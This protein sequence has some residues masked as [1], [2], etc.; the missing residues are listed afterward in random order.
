MA[1]SVRFDRYPNMTKDFVSTNVCYFPDE[2]EVPS[3]EKNIG[4]LLNCSS[5]NAQT[6]TLVLGTCNQL[7]LRTWDLTFCVDLSP[8]MAVKKNIF[9]ILQLRRFPG[10]TEFL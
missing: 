6:C 2:L 4:P 10:T 1:R 3:V 7:N 9:S 8:N 5:F